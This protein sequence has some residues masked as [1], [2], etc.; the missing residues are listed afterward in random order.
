MTLSIGSAVPT[1]AITLIRGE[2]VGGRVEKRLSFPYGR[3]LVVGRFFA[4]VSLIVLIAV[5]VAFLPSLTVGPVAALA[6]ILAAYF[7]LFAVSPLLTE[8]WITRSRLILRQGWYFRTVIP[9]SEIE[10]IEALD[11][12]G[13]LQAPL[14]V[15]RPFGQRALF[16]T[17]GRTNLVSVRLTRPRRFWQ[18]FGLGAREIV[19]DVLDR[20]KFLE[21]IDERRGLFA[22]VQAHRADADLRN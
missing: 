15:H 12:I 5:A 17:G 4:L 14:G 3:T 9:F 21:A 8:H 13:P 20:T 2:G 22:P 18:S 6:V 10:S 1:R 16:V 11:E 7:V 19:F